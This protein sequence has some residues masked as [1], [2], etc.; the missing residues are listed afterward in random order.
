MIV[1]LRNKVIKITRMA[2]IKIKIRKTK[3]IIKY[4]Y[5]YISYNIKSVTGENIF[6]T[7]FLT[8][9]VCNMSKHCLIKEFGFFINILITIKLYTIFFEN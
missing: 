5:G 1:L 3:N 7:S 8:S 9:S 6:F 4:M 2:K